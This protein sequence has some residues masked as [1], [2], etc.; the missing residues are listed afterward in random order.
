M[1]NPPNNHNIADWADIAL[2]IGTAEAILEDANLPVEYETSI[3]YGSQDYG[4]IHFFSIKQEQDKD[5]DTN[6]GLGLYGFVDDSAEER[7]FSELLIVH[8]DSDNNVYFLNM[9]DKDN[10]GPIN[11]LLIHLQENYPANDNP[12]LKKILDQ[13]AF[14][15]LYTG[16]YDEFRNDEFRIKNLDRFEVLENPDILKAIS[17]GQNIADII[18]QDISPSAKYALKTKTYMNTFYNN[19]SL[20]ITSSLLIPNLSSTTNDLSDFDDKISD[21]PELE[22]VLSDENQL[23]IYTIQQ[24]DGQLFYF[25]ENLADI[26]QSDDNYD[27][28]DVSP[29]S[30]NY[31]QNTPNNEP[32]SQNVISL[33]K[34]LLAHA[35]DTLH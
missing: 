14:F 34:D 1:N 21:V 24:Y 28:I 10:L 31:I 32:F 3:A 9:L 17:L 20:S 26:N 6:I 27:Y 2:I 35:Y 29:D 30:S 33:I 12:L 15:M 11:R 13:L 23:I 25:I 4:Y 18:C 22:I 7:D 19:Y 5:F 8:F 16:H